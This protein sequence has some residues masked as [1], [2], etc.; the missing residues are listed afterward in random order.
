MKNTTSG[1]TSVYSAIAAPT[2]GI[3]L[4]PTALILLC[5]SGIAR[6]EDYFD[7]A[8]LE[9]ANPQQK[10]ADLH[11][12]AKTGGQQPGT[13]PVSI[14]VNNQEI[15][16]SEVTFV[17]SNGALQPQLT[18]AQ[19]AEYGVN[20]SAFPA[21]NTLH[22]GEPFTRIERYIPDASSRF[23]FATQRLNLSIPQAAMNVQ[24][25]GY[26]DPARWDEGI[27]AAFVNYNLTGSQTRQSDDNSRSSYLNLRSGVN[28]GAWR[29]RN[30]SSM[31]YDRTRRWNSQSTWL[32]RDLKSLKSLLRMGDTF[33]S[34]D[35]F[36]SVQ[37]RGVQLMSDDEMLPDS[38]RGFAPTIRGMAHSNA[39]VTISQHGYVIYETFVSPG[40][41]AIND[42][43]P[44]AQSGDLEVQ[45]KE[46]DGSVRTFTQPFSAVPFMLREGRVKFSLSAGRYHSG[47]SQTPSPTFLQGTL[48]YGLPAEFTLYGGSQLAQDY[49]SWALGV[50]RGFGELGSLGGDATWANT[51]TPSGKRSAGHSLR[52]QYQ[53]D[54]AGTGTSFSLASYRY[55]SGGY[56]DFSEANALESRNG[57][58]DNK[59]S[60][61][62]IS[63]SQAFG[64]MSSLAISAWSQEYWHRQS[65]DETIHL[66]FYSAWRGVSW[67]VGYYYTQS[68]DRQKADRSWSF[69]LSIPLGGPLAESAIS[70]ST[71][72]DNNGRT[73]QQASL[74]GSIPRNPHLY[75]SLQQGYANGGQ[76]SNSSA[77]LDYHGGYG[78]AQLGY[79]QDS[80]SHQLTWGAAGSI[81]AHPHGVTLGQTVGDSFAIVRAPGAADVAIQNG[82]NV[83]TDWRGYA[84]V[85]S[86]TAYRK[87]TITLD[88]ESL[89]DDA[90]VELEG[91]TV[92]PGGGAVV[93]ANYQTHIGN[94][95]LFTLSD[96]RGPLPFGAS[97]RL[98]KAEDEQG[99]VPGGMV[100][101]GGQVY[102]SGIPQE[103][104]LDV[105]WNADNI[106]RKCALHFHLTDTVQQGQSPVKTVSGVCQ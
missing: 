100:A 56:Y 95:V 16:Q 101:D 67:G 8:A 2:G 51:K 59:R 62:E 52:V 9:F 3:L 76:G 45:V 50:G 24:S 74:Y 94:R 68:S 55:S 12:F 28:F 90:D 86:L 26:V 48:F 46:S 35:V 84:V 18:P 106:S 63:V 27:P 19:L 38:Q 41:F 22:E 71:T 53:K 78:T 70:Y 30:V 66:G 80:G 15:A 105:A 89:A 91:Q 21:F 92:I 87:N 6:A 96:S 98:R 7:P 57:L 82:S 81:V 39:K 49:Q 13:Y 43:Y 58:V 102:L 75:Y 47:Q 104:T 61:E 31:E 79:R 65:R 97:V 1:M 5:Q 37:F 42:L 33:T 32:Q 54:F 14:W 34:G 73:S 103:G 72:S 40:A 17:D 93:Q 10:T 20:V 85:P 60:R 69:N 4:L 36:D 77:S 44:T 64:G 23:D 11:Y 83:H 25:R 29:L 88:T 99:A